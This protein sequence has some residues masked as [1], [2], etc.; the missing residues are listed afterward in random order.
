MSETSQA[1]N[2]GTRRL[3]LSPSDWQAIL[4][5]VDVVLLNIALMSVT[6]WRLDQPAGWSG[7]RGNPEW[8][9]LLTLIWLLVA[10]VLH[11]YHLRQ[12]AHLGRSL[13]GVIAPWFGLLG[14]YLAIPYVTPPMLHSRLTTLLFAGAC[15]GALSIGRIAKVAVLSR[16]RFR[17][18]ILIIG[19]VEETEELLKAIREHGHSGY[20]VAGTLGAESMSP[21]AELPLLG[22]LAD[23]P[24]VLSRYRISDVVTSA[25]PNA[26]EE[27]LV[28]A[29]LDSRELGIEVTL[30]P[31]L[32]EQLTG[33]VSLQRLSVQNLAFLL[34]RAGEQPR[35]YE[36]AK[37]LIDLAI[38]LA[39]LAI[40]AVVSIVI[41]PLILLDHWGP[42]FIQQ[43]R[44]GR[45]GRAFTLRKFRTMVPNA[46]EDG[47][48]WAV[49]D[50][51]RVTTIGW[52]LRKTHLDELSQAI[53]LVTGEMSFIG[54]RPERPEFVA[55]LERVVPFY[56][57]RHAVKPGITGWA[58]VNYPY[59]AS[60]DDA[61]IKLQY[62]LYYIK[63]ASLSLDAQIAIG[64]IG[65][66]LALRGR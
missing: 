17:R 19:S 13:S 3:S 22:R 42:I 10:G 8:Y 6:W 23:L 4:L 60:V 59:G 5:T 37:R 33:R 58:Q 49:E 30:I 12:P 9:L 32:Y 61:R 46:E 21:E 7:I 27:E 40:L 18:R 56:R 28:D 50:D 14:L 26:E 15:L 29:V 48:R 54:P 53:N 62:D 47:P 31:D 16:P 39:G 55:E 64:T 52:L 35:L 66:V 41:I 2:V 43:R 20:R 57:A 25:T 34:P 38:G 44:I 65:L 51:S 36:V 11:V 45:G 24:D 63:H 1:I